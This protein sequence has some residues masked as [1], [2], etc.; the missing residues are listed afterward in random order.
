MAWEEEANLRE[1]MRSNKRESPDGALTSSQIQ[2]PSCPPLGL[3]QGLRALPVASC[4]PGGHY[5]T[6]A[7]PYSGQSIEQEYEYV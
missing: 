7:L 2:A 1:E 3:V 4:S 5:N 6:E